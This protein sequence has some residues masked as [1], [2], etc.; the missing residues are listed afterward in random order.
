VQQPCP[1]ALALYSERDVKQQTIPTIHSAHLFAHHA[2][3]STDQH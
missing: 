1:F 3:T 2:Q